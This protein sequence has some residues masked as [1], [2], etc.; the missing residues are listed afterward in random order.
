M[1]PV[2]ADTAVFLPAGSAWKGTWRKSLDQVDAG[3]A[4]NLEEG[5][6]RLTHVN[7]FIVPHGLPTCQSFSGV[8]LVGSEAVIF[9]PS[10][11]EFP[12]EVS[13]SKA[14][15]PCLGFAGRI[16]RWGLGICI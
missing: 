4:W 15:K 8:T 13:N 16:S 11:L 2:W 6:W 7:I 12:E 1:L 5:S 9:R 3:Q 10:V 14:P